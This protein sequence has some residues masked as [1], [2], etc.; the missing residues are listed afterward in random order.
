MNVDKNA[1]PEEIKKSYRKLS[2][3]K[4][5]DTGGNSEEFN[6]LKNAYAVLANPSKRERYDKT[7]ASESDNVNGV[8]FAKTYLL[9]KAFIENPN[10]IM[11][12]I[13]SLYKQKTHEIE[14]QIHKINEGLK[15]VDE[16]GKRILKSPEQ[17]ILKNIIEKEKYTMINSIEEYEKKKNEINEAFIEIK[18]EYE[19]QENEEESFYFPNRRMF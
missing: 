2:K 18:I 7:G 4:H 19:F 10:N 15:K 13:R 3:K 17:D 9:E 8:I 11:N 5:P 14:Q 1:T 6:E 12:F 16:F